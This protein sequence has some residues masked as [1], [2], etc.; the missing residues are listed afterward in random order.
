VLVAAFYGW[1]SASSILTNKAVMGIWHFEYPLTMIGCQMIVCFVLLYS[2]RAFGW[3]SFPDWNWGTALKALPLAAAHLANTLVGLVALNLIDVPMFGTLRRLVALCVMLLEY[4]LLRQR[5][6]WIVIFSVGLMVSGALIG[7]WSD[8][9]FDMLGYALTFLVNM[10]TAASLVLIPRTGKDANLSS[11]GLML[12]QVT[13][14]FPAVVVLFILSGEY[15]RIEDYPYLYDPHFQISFFVSCLQ[16]FLLNYSIFWCT[17]IN[18]PL[19][20]TVTGQLK[21]VLQIA[22]GFLFFE[23]PI[24]PMNIFGITVGI[25]GSF[26]Y[27]FAKYQENGGRKAV[28]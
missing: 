27:T 10:I 5:F 3:I 14:S 25:S 18:S 12:Y 21:N 17:Q 23:V 20:T 16:I 13:L 1:M 28:N 7:G 2:L 24:V 4:F 6:S 19:T 11:F 15:Q 26:I 9:K 22:G 8:L